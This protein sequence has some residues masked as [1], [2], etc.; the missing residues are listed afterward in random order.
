MA[1]TVLYPPFALGVVVMAIPGTSGLLESIPGD[2]VDGKARFR[3]TQVRGKAAVPE[4]VRDG[5]RT[6]IPATGSLPGVSTRRAGRAEV[7]SRIDAMSALLTRS[8]ALAWS[9]F[10]RLL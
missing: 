10:F 2:R 1:L 7:S 6:A 8:A 3:P 5:D 9:L 4:A